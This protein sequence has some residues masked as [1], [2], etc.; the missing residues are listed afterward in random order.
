MNHLVKLSG[1]YYSWLCYGVSS[2]IA[3]LYILLHNNYLDDPR[4]TPPPPP[5]GWL[6]SVQIIDDWW[7]GGLLVIAG[8]VLITGVLADSRTL[9]S[10][11][12]IILAPL[13]GAFAVFFIFR[14]LFGFHFNL[15]WLFACLSLALLFGV[16]S[17]GD[18]RGR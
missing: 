15:T 3:G 12:L 8:V 18:Q 6:Y 17:R 5:Q 2:L 9:R 16:A 10:A 11:G 13:F 4:I 14:G 7:F 1:R